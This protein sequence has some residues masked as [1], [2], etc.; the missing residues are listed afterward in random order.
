MELPQSFLGV[1][2]QALNRYLNLDPSVKTRLIPLAGKVVAIEFIGLPVGFFIRV[3]NDGLELL[4][5][6]SE[7]PDTVIRGTPFAFMALRLQQTQATKHTFSGDM[8]VVGN[9]HLGQA[10][11][12]ILMEVNIDWE[13]QLAQYLG[14]T[15]AH[16][17]AAQVKYGKQLLESTVKRMQANLQEYVQEEAHI[18]P[19]KSAVEQF[20]ADVD[21]LYLATERL[22]ANI[23]LLQKQLKSKPRAAH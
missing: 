22:E 9:I 18:A 21:A 12:G 14:E 15:P 17:V 19:A 4:G 2:S 16:F 13:G 7:K 8:E 6:Y 3:Q 11:Q 5:T 10:L 20:Y 1:V 23:Q